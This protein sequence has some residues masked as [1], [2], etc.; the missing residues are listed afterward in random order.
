MFIPFQKVHNRLLFLT[1]IVLS[2]SQ[3]SATGQE[4]NAQATSETM[5]KE[6]YFD[7]WLPFMESYRALNLEQFKALQA[8]ELIKVSIDRNTIQPTSVYLQEIAGFFNRF[9]Q[10]NRQL[11]IKFSILSTA[12]GTGSVY[13]TGYYAIG[14]RAPSSEA[15]KNMGYG[16][17]TVVLTKTDSGWKISLDADKQIQIEEAEFRKSGVVYELKE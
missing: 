14:A 16:Y 9:K 2:V 15:F 13:Q 1:F 4:I 7:I 11:D 12:F 8:K 10:M 5:M 3:F 17:F 6:I